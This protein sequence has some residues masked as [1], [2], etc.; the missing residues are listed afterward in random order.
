[1]SISIKVCVIFLLD[2]GFSEEEG[3]LE[4][5][6][7]RFLCGESF[8]VLRGLDIGSCLTVTFE[9]LCEGMSAFPS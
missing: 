7:T 8:S 5:S 6:K 2:F 9:E 1:V 3:S 4:A